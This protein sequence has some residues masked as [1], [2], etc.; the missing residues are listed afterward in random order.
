MVVDQVDIVDIAVPKAKDDSPI[1]GNDNTPITLQLTPQG[2]Y[3]IPWQIEIRGLPGH[4]KIGQNQR[5][6]SDQIGPE[7]PAVATLMEP[8]QTPVPE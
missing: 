8:L 5:N 6:P 2:V 1:P 7:S 4:F 3:S